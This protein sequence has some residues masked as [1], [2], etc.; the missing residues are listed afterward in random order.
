MSMP[1]ALDSI[2]PLII[3]T[4]VG[5][6]LPS[7][8][9]DGVAVLVTDPTM[10]RAAGVLVD[11]R[12]ADATVVGYATP[13]ALLATHADGVRFRVQAFTDEP[14]ARTWLAVGN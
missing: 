8:W 7:D 5:Q 3:A 12:R 13:A 6:V 11:L 14:A 2:S 1:F 10:P 9:R 4:V